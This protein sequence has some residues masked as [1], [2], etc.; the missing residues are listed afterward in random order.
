MSKH[1]TKTDLPDRRRLDL[2]CLNC[3]FASIQISSYNSSLFFEKSILRQGG[4]GRGRGI[5]T[6][7]ETPT[8]PGVQRRSSALRVGENSSVF[9][10]ERES[11]WAN[12]C[13]SKSKTKKNVI[14]PPLRPRPPRT[15]PPKK[16]WEN[17]H[18]QLLSL[19]HTTHIFLIIPRM[20]RSL[21]LGLIKDFIIVPTIEIITPR[22]LAQRGSSRMFS[23]TTTVAIGLT[24]GATIYCHG[25]FVCT[26]FR[27]G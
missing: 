10:L 26:I 12:G 22:N 4:G 19:A 11:Q 8:L 21:R 13:I 25:Y 23:I 15:P 6:S 20:S 5:I 3:F 16:N 14:S 27:K 1:R 17:A 2:A 18:N 9:F 24:I 7:K